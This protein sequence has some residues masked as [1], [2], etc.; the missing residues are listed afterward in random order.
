MIVKNIDT[1]TQLVF[2][3]NIAYDLNSICT[4]LG[5]V[6]KD[7]TLYKSVD[8]LHNFNYYPPNS[9]GSVLSTKISVKKVNT[10]IINKKIEFTLS[11]NTLNNMIAILNR[12]GY[13]YTVN[14]KGIDFIGNM[15]LDSNNNLISNDGIKASINK[16][17]NNSDTSKMH[18]FIYNM[19]LDNGRMLYPVLKRFSNTIHLFKGNKS[20]LTGY[21][22]L[23]DY[24]YT[25][26]MPQTGIK[27]TMKSSDIKYNINLNSNIAEIE[28]SDIVNGKINYIL[29]FNGSI[30]HV[31]NGSFDPYILFTTSPVIMQ[32]QKMP[33][34]VVNV[35][36]LHVF[37]TPLLFNN[38]ETLAKLRG[39]INLLS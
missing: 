21:I 25:M 12:Y 14:I 34:Q 31:N 6:K 15:V 33:F 22:K 16:S 2:T 26:K 30:N 5:Y 17:S 28:I 37:I 23:D 29:N 4:E 38:S 39:G 18:K 1:N 32:N 36:G 20:L 35:N 8:I 11:E 7:G 13:D 3:N 19:S 10:I 9:S 24:L 27:P